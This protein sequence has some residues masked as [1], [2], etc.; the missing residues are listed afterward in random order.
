MVSDAPSS[1]PNARSTEHEMQV[2]VGVSR[3]V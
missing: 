1:A 2:N 3:S